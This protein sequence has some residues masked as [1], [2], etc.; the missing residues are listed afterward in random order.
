[1]TAEEALISISQTVIRMRKVA[2]RS[3]VR[4]VVL[5]S[6]NLLECPDDTI[7]EHAIREIE[8]RMEI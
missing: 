2:T 6:W 7:I 3:G 1:M 4:A 5:E 8:R